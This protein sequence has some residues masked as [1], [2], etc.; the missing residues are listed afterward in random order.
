MTDSALRLQAN[1]PG[2]TMPAPAYRTCLAIG[3]ITL[4]SVVAGFIVV[5]RFRNE[6]QPSE[7]GPV[8]SGLAAE[9]RNPGALPTPF[10]NVGPEAKF[11]GS[12]A[13]FSSAFKPL[14]KSFDMRLKSRCSSFSPSILTP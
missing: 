11:V 8:A 14:S 3:I 7:K 9:I 5:G 2:L 4:A 10:L 12:A 13:C 1:S 6:Q